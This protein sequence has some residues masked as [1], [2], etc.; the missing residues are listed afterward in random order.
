MVKNV[1]GNKT[2]GKARKTFTNNKSLN[3]IIKTD[4]YDYGFVSKQFGSGRFEIMCYDKVKR[5]GIVR[6]NIKRSARIAVTNVV[7]VSL[8]DFQ[9]NTCD[10]THVYNIEE[11][12]T[13]ISKGFIDNNFAKEGSLTSNEQFMALP[14]D[15]P[16]HK[17][18]TITN[19]PKLTKDEELN[20]DDVFN[21]L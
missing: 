10:I 19:L 13:L 14:D 9:D 2:K 5:I 17:D 3:D 7:M 16:V 18:I 12:D 20:I 1:G 8:R 4:G 11:L 21:N 6:G 15:K